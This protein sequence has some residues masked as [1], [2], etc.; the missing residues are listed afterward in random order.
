MMGVLQKGKGR[1][2]QRASTV[3][4]GS[5]PGSATQPDRPAVNLLRATVPRGST[6][7]NVTLI[8]GPT[9]QLPFFFPPP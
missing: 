2:L 9:S 6:P 7:F 1:N 3:A 5:V 4:S 8:N